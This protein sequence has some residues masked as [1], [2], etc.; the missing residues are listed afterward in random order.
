MSL[1]DDPL[2][3]AREIGDSICAAA[4]PADDGCRWFSRDPGKEGEGYFTDVYLGATGIACFLLN[5]FE[6]TRA[7]RYREVA[8]Q[9]LPWLES[10]AAA[11][12]ERLS[13]PGLHAGRGALVYVYMRAAAITGDPALLRRAEEHA[14]AC[15]AME[16]GYTELFFGTA[17]TGLVF[18]HLHRGT[19]NPEH[20]QWAEAAGDALLGQ[21]ERVGQ[22]VRWPLRTRPVADPQAWN[23]CYTGMAHGAAGIGCFLAELYR[24]TGAP[25]FAE[26]VRGTARRLIEVAIREGPVWVWDR[27]DP[28]SDREKLVQWCHGAP[29]NGLFFLRGFTV[30]GDPELREAAEQCA[31]ATL[32]A[33]DI[34]ENPCQCHG[35]CGNAELFLDLY[36][37][38]GDP[39]YREMAHQFAAMALK[40]RRETERGVEWQSHTPGVTTPDYLVGSAGVGQFFLRL[41]DS[42]ST[43]MPFLDVG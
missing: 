3:L 25:R 27:F 31:E 6:R 22:G 10:Q 23:G 7:S 15:R 20:L 41:A 17:G 28:A 39:R 35:L 33:G 42:R 9:A 16:A 13:G 24:A 34:R 43:P 19:G 40:Y 26:A 8:L 2:F 1:L 32:A 12:E 14:R 5:L 29:G 30:L 36:H 21:A 4:E 37:A 18:L 11:G 38:L